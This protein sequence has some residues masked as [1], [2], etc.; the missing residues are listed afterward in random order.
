LHDVIFPGA[1]NDV[2]VLKISKKKLNKKLE[3]ILTTAK[4]F[5]GALY[6]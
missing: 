1:E 6:I 2:P 3:K 5:H 4:T